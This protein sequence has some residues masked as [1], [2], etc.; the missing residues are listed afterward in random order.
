MVQMVVDIPK[1]QGPT[2]L[3]QISYGH[4]G[5]DKIALK[6]LTPFGVDHG[7]NAFWSVLDRIKSPANQHGIS[8]D[9]L[10]NRKEKTN[11]S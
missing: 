8:S 7:S 11:K 9:V 5:Q 10:G 3:K 1:Y 4:C 2:C 6:I